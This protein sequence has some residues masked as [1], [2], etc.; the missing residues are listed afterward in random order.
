MQTEKIITGSR[1]STRTELI[2]TMEIMARGLVTP[3][4]GMRVPF[5]EVET[6]F[7]AIRSETLLGRGALTYG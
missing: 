7:D 4:V 1:H 2:E 3:V 5:A 6:I